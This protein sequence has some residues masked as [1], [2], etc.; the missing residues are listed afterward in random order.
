[1]ILHPRLPVTEHPQSGTKHREFTSAW[2]AVF[3]TQK[4]A[5]PRW[6][7]IA[8]PDHAALAG[9]LAQGISSSAFPKLEE[10]AIRAI[11][12]HDEGWQSFDQ[13][14]MVRDE[15]PLSFLDLGPSEFLQAWTGSILT[16]EQVGPLAG[17]MVSGHFL[18]LARVHIETRGENSEVR[19]FLQDESARQD[20]LFPQQNHTREQLSVLIDVLQ[21]CDLLSLYLCCGALE[22]I[23]FP[24][25]FDG[26]SIRLYREG[27]M[28]CL[29]PHILGDGMSLGVSARN[30]P[31]EEAKV[32]IPIL[33][34]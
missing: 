8:Q 27:G 7:L 23:E 33:L 31:L 4:A 2:Q 14:P 3:G 18:R 29:E 26:H 6:L 32:T 13:D 30:F 21:F 28:C 25:R 19:K 24:Q 1:M 20:R 12:V 16:A 15:R 9:D 34:G 17:M 10:E 5:A 22:A 11:S